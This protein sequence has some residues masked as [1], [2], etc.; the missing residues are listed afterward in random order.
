M[1]CTCVLVKYETKCECNAQRMIYEYM[2]NIHSRKWLHSKFRLFVRRCHSDSRPFL[3]L[4]WFCF[5][6]CVGFTLVRTVRVHKACIL[7]LKQWNG[8]MASATQPMFSVLLSETLARRGHLCALN[9]EQIVTK[10]LR[11]SAY[12][13]HSA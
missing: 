9:S 4:L 12:T 3:F 6:F 11:R 1:R 13:Y 7:Y 10:L 5:G 8:Y 2:Y